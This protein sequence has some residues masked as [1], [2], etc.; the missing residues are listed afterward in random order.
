MSKRNGHGVLV[1]HPALL[2]PPS[3]GRVGD[4]PPCCAELA[5]YAWGPNKPEAARAIM[6]L[7]EK[8][9]TALPRIEVKPPFRLLLPGVHYTPEHPLVDYL[10]T[11]GCEFAITCYAW[12]CPD[13]E[14][15]KHFCKPTCAVFM[16]TETFRLPNPDDGNLLTW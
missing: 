6:E 13:E 4:P 14:D 12:V 2:V 9:A 5:V 1:P 16:D 3:T 15:S 10:R 7:A 8:P 11:T